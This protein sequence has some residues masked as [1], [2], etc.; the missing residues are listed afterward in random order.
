LA[1]SQFS[2]ASIRQSQLSQR[3]T[4][5]W[6]FE[7]VLDK[8]LF[9]VSSPEK[10]KNNEA[11]PPATIIKIIPK[12]QNNFLLGFSGEDSWGIWLCL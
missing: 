7:S 8:E 10:N 3:I 9:S 5:D 1:R 4:D 2:E 12:V 6:I 11:T